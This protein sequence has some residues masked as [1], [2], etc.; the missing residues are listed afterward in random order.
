[1]AAILRIVDRPGRRIEVILRDELPTEQ[2]LNNDIIYV[3]PLSGLGPLFGFYEA[4]SR[5]RY[6][7]ADSTL[8]DVDAHK[9]FSPQGVLSAERVD[10]ALAAKFVGPN[11]NHIMVFTSGVRNAG[12]LQ[13][14]RTVTSPDGLDR[15]EKGL[16]AKPGALPDSFEALLTV[17]GF[18]QTDL[19][20]DIIDVNPLPAR[21][22][23]DRLGQTR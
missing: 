17:A 6:N 7:A 13:V 8:T 11:G 10:Y 1:M 4:R 12:L 19:S 3:G 2:I 20:A 16:R 15:L 9:S 14:V 23:P 5:Y 22:N 18:R 21:L